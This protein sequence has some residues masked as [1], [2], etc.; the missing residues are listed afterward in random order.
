[1]QPPY[2]VEIDGFAPENS[3]FASKPSRI[4]QDGL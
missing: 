1:M 2:T 3:R 4:A